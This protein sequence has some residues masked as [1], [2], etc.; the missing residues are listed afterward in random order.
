MQDALDCLLRKRSI[1]EVPKKNFNNGAVTLKKHFY[2][3]SFNYNDKEYPSVALKNF[4]V[5]FLAPQKQRS[6]VLE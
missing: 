4:P 2:L 5:L 3:F 6:F 1:S